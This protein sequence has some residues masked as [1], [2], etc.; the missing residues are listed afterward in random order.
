MPRRSSGRKANPT[1]G[2]RPDPL[3]AF[4]LPIAEQMRKLGT[5]QRW[6]D[7]AIVF[8]RGDRVARLHL[9]LRGRMRIAMTAA[10]G[11]E[12][13][14]RWSLPGEFVGIVSVVTQRPFPVDA[15]AFDH[16]ESLTYEWDAL[17]ALLETDVQAVFVV[18]R[19]V[20]QHT[21]D[22]TN[23]I[24]ARTA[25]TLTARVLAVLEHLAVV[26]AVPQPGGERALAVS[27]SDIAHAVGASRQA[28]NAALR[29]LEK[30]GQ[31]RLGYRLVVLQRPAGGA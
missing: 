6:P 27:Q 25:Q 1:F 30:K 17:K 19:I 31:I 2:E 29:D 20:G 8:R 5:L 11:G 23:L 15:V 22:M 4:P 10:D 7:G 14:I 24:V 9:L 3:A 18:A 21:A 12:L 28:V 26:H 16:C 13:F